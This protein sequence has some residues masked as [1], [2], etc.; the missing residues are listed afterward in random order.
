M[1]TK[2]IHKELSLFFFLVGLV[3]LGFLVHRV[4]VGQVMDVFTSLGFKIGY[5]FIF[6]VTWYL[7]QSV[8]WWWLFDDGDVRVPFLHV[9][10]A[11]ISGEAV[12]TVTPVSFLGGDPL[13]IYLLQKR[14]SRTNATASVVIDRTMYMLGVCMLLL[15]TLIAAWFYLPLP[16]AWQILFPVFTVLLFA[17]FVLLVIFEKNGMF[18]MLSRVLQRTGIQR[19]RLAELSDKIENLDRQIGS[20]YKENKT[21]F[22]GV[23]LLQFVG[24]FLGVVEIYLIVSLLN[25]PVPFI[26][27]LFMASLTILINMAFVFIPGSMGVMEGGYGALLYLLKLDPAY[28]IVIQLIRRIRSFF[29]IGVGLIVILIYRPHKV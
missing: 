21:L 2:K 16:G 15:V 23:M 12:N 13:R 3:L 25:L 7:V 5:V 28:G 26:H 8:A 27:C 9:F 18:S 10:L 24:R 29:W 17:A 20:F 19:D 14:V 1:N 4:G 6:P 11:K 22:F